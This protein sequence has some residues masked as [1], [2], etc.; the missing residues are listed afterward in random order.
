MRAAIQD[1]LQHHQLA[2]VREMLVT[3]DS[4]GGVGIMNNADFIH[5]LLK[6]RPTSLYCI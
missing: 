3:G 5:S 4:A 6:Y 1:L 2:D